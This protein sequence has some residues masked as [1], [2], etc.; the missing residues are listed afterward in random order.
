[1]VAK[2]RKRCGKQSHTK[3]N[4]KKKITEKKDYKTKD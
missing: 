3:S 2:K 1:M 4:K